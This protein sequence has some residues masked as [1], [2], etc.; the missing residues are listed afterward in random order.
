MNNFVSQSV[1]FS[2]PTLNI[3]TTS[4]GYVL[5]KDILIWEI[6]E[7]MYNINLPCICLLI[8]STVLGTI[9]NAAAIY[10]FGFKMK[11]NNTNIFT[12]WLSVYE[13]L[14]CLLNIYEVYDKRF[15]MYSGTFSIL[16]KLIRFL[17]I[18]S[19]SASA[20]L[21]LCIAFDRYFMVC[22]PLKRKSP[23]ERNRAII[24]A[25][26]VP[27][28]CVWPMGIFHGQEIRPTPYEGIYGVDCSDDDRYRKSVARKIFNF[29]VMLT[30]V[31]SIVILIVLYVLIFNSMKEWK[32]SVIGESHNRKEGK[33]Q[34]KKCSGNGKSNKNGLSKKSYSNEGNECN[35]AATDVF[36]ECNCK[37]SRGISYII[38]ENTG[39]IVPKNTSGGP[40]TSCNTD[41]QTE[42]KDSKTK[43]PNTSISLDNPQEDEEV[44]CDRSFQTDDSV[45]SMRIESNHTPTVKTFDLVENSSNGIVI[46]DRNSKTDRRSKERQTCV[47]KNKR[48]GRKRKTNMTTL[49]FFLVSVLYIVSFLPT[50]VIEALNSMSAVYEADLSFSTRQGIVIAN[51]SYFLNGSFNPIIYFVFNKGFRLEVINIFTR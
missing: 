43:L 13:L 26:V 39:E 6:N 42:E 3:S 10:I 36:A 32:K 45:S 38:R 1:T 9:G 34:L 44:H 18:F 51:L 8:I 35:T 47:W 2:M 20:F 14:T 22:K 41:K 33:L 11:R 31:T 16:C 19:T 7:R 23:T 21:L 37:S 30:I 28:V 12:A 29:F 4:P 48:S 25:F 49:M 50:V 46:C 5:T 17:I 40:S 15:P 27:L 24:A